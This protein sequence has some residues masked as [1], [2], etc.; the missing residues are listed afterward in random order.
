MTPKQL[1]KVAT[2][3]SLAFSIARGEDVP[4]VLLREFIYETAPFPQCHA[5]TIAETPAGLVAAWFGG[6]REKA[7]DVGIWVSRRGHSGTWSAPVEVANGVQ[8]DGTR[9]PSWNPVLF[10]PRSGGLLMLFY[11][12]GPSPD[13]WWGLLRTSSD[14]GETWSEAIALPEGILGPIKNKPVQLADGEILCPSSSERGGPWR[15]HFERTR[16]FGRTWT[17]VLPASPGVPPLDAIQP[18]VLFLGGDKLLAI[19]RTRQQVIF[20]VRSD[21]VGKTWGP[22]ERTTLPNPN[23]GTDAVT[24]RDG[25]HLLVYNHTTHGRTPLNLALSSDGQHW[26]PSLV[27]EKEP[28]EFSYPAVIQSEDEMVHL[29]YTW[30]RVKIRHVV[31]DPTKLRLEE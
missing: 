11:K 12:V 10:R 22:M 28:G 29:T 2:L 9:F 4:A 17:T 24:L 26:R 6:A 16:D 13:A 23:S 14:E 21:D 18:S 20:Q 19:G 15:V 25:R 3:A 7:P 31:V 5:S 30:N 8:P 27:L 1:C